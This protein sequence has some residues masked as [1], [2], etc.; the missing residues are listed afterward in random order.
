ML[1]I[2]EVE[3]KSPYKLKC[4]FNTGETKLFNVL[5]VIQNHHLING[6][7]ELLN[8]DIFKK[9]IVGQMGEILWKNIVKEENSDTYFDYDISAEYVY[10]NSILV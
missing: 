5:P 1:K 2:L 3:I 10:E 8:D 4:K 6:V 9:V 7:S